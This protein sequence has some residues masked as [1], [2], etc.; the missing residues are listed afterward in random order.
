MAA[1]PPSPSSAK[2]SQIEDGEK[3][4]TEET[5]ND[6]LDVQHLTGTWAAIDPTGKIPESSL[7]LRHAGGQFTYLACVDDDAITTALATNDSGGGHHLPLRMIS[8]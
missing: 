5:K 3:R 6:T 7:E 4:T 1:A 2:T 8:A